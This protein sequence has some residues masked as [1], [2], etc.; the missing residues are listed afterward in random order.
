MHDKA[1]PV[2]VSYLRE[3]I[4]E[5]HSRSRALISGLSD[6]QLMGP[7]LDIVNP[8]RWEIGHVA[9]FH[10]NFILRNLDGRAPMIAGADALYDSAK[11]AHE[12]RW[13]LPLPDLAATVRYAEDVRDALLARIGRDDISTEQESYY[14]QLTVFHEDMHDEAFVCMRQILGY[15]AP[16][17]AGGGGA[18]SEAAPN[19]GPLPGDVEV[20][21]GV[22]MLGGEPCDAYVMDNEQWGHGYELAPFRI[23]RAPVTNEEF[24]A[25]VDHGGYR[26]EP[27][28]SPQGWG[29][30]RHAKAEHPVYWVPDGGG[31]QQRTFDAHEKLRPHAPVIHVN[32]FEADAYCRWAGR[33]LPTEAEWEV[34]A[35]RAPDP[36]S[37]ILRGPK[38]RYPWGNEAPSPA[39]AN[40]DASLGGVVDVA[41]FPDGDSAWGCRQMVGN[42]WEWTNSIFQPFPGFTAGPYTDYSAPW[43][44]EGRMVLRG[45]AWATRSRFIWNTWRNFFTPERRD[46]FAGFRTCAV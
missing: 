14:H 25:F 6:D 24:A 28:W 1:A 2:P 40:L 20:P 10:E 39:R 38:R 46:V 31:W 22:H 11:V 33:R 41:A 15:P 4:I 42:S 29:W 8:F 17:L 18:A 34:A 9:W 44:A 27:L 12:V 23:A 16:R 45:G 35:S 30:R 37:D 26:K 3:I 36:G 13:D 32:W 5:A 19:A 43:F 7:R 21:G